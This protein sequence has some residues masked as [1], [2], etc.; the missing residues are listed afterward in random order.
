MRYILVK[1]G[2]VSNAIEIDPANITDTF[3]RNDLGDRVG[4]TM[5]NGELVIATRKY[6]PPEGFDF[7]ETDQYNI[8]D[9]YPKPEV[10]PTA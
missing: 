8:G 2:Y 10:E 9:V 1:D 5:L 3:M 7:I 4:T 6:L